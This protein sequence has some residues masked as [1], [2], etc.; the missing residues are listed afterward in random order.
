MNDSVI[1]EEIK[2][3]PP[4]KLPSLMDCIRFLS[5]EKCKINNSE[6]AEYGS[7]SSGEEAD[8]WLS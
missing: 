3:V 2:R 7:F 1:L 8:S 5:S 4:E 6:H